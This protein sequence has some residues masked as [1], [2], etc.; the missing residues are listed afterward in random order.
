M[1][2]A[3]GGTL[4]PRGRHQSIIFP[5]CPNRV[6]CV[7]HV[8]LMLLP[9]VVHRIAAKDAAAEENEAVWEL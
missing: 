6:S 3:G 1:C 7:V 9:A 4:R 8:F 5:L 2:V